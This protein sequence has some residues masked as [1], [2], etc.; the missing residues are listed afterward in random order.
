MSAARKK[1]I[2]N[3]LPHTPK[4]RLS[5]VLVSAVSGVGEEIVF[6]A[7]LFAILYQMTGDYWVA[8]AI[9]ALFFALSHLTHGLISTVIRFFVALGLQWLVQISSGLYAAIA[10]HFIHNLLNGFVYGA[11]GRNL[12]ESSLPASVAAKDTGAAGAAQQSDGNLSLAASLGKAADPA[13]H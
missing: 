13:D 10:V 3:F 12:S 4:E 1:R 7:A 8:G 9:S 11:L 5:W 6:R 2:S